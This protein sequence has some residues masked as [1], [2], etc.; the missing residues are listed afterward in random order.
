MPERKISLK[1]RVL[2][3]LNK[4]CF[5]A[6]GA[7]VAA[8]ALECFLVPNNIIDGGIVG[9]SMILSYLTKYNLGLLILVLNIPFL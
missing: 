1:E 2:F 4:L 5:L 3:V 6:F 7:F 8:F 9:I